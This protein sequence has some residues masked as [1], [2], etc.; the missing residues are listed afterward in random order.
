MDLHF[1]G[2]VLYRSPPCTYILTRITRPLALVVHSTVFGT[3]KTRTYFN[4][5]A[6]WNCPFNLTAF[7]TGN[8]I[9]RE[10]AQICIQVV[11]AGLSQDRHLA[12]VAQ[13]SVECKWL[14]MFVAS[15][16]TPLPL[17][18]S[19]RAQKWGSE[20][21][22]GDAGRRKP[23]ER[24]SSRTSKWLITGCKLDCKILCSSR[25]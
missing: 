4:L 7:G 3:K 25:R 6:V 9:D 2:Q 13:R 15:V 1:C 5:P 12:V 23:V 18:H 10:A 21:R 8:V 20:S 14:L 17:C 22:T 24:S 16:D 19:S 11:F